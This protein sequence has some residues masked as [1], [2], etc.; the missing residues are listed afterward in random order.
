MQPIDLNEH[1]IVA[2]WE[3]NENS[4]VLAELFQVPQ[5]LVDLIKCGKYG[6]KFTK[7]LVKSKKPANNQRKLTEEQLLEIYNSKEST[8]VLAQRYQVAGGTIRNV[9]SGRT[10]KQFNHIPK[11]LPTNEVKIFGEHN[12]Q[13]VLIESQVKEIIQLFPTHSNAKLAEL[14][15]VS[16]ECISS[17][18]K[19]QSWIYLTGGIKSPRSNG[20]ASHWHPKRKLTAEAA[21]DI[22]SSTASN[23]ELA[24]RYGVLPRT[25]KKVRDGLAWKEVNKMFSQPQ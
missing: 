20:M 11:A 7:D 2:I 23:K 13:A 22:R 25:I 16:V 15:A 5:K 4:F 12:G 10:F 14:Y 6:S 17:I 3:T 8:K 1:D 21:A 18:R 9:R 24:A 19:G